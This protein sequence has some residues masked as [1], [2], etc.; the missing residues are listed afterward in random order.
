MRLLLYGYFMVSYPQNTLCQ[1]QVAK[2]KTKIVNILV[3]HGKYQ[4]KIIRVFCIHFFKVRSKE[5]SPIT[6]VRNQ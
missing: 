2:Y 4:S 1:T 5:F 3:I 6:A